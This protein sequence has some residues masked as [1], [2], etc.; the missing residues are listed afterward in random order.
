MTAYR[1]AGSL[2]CPDC[3]ASLRAFGARWVCDDCTGIFIR[4]D[5]LRRAIAE[6]GAGAIEL[7]AAEAE[8]ASADAAPAAPCPSCARP[9]DRFRIALREHPNVF[10]GG[11]PSAFPFR[12]DGVEL[13]RADAI[14]EDTTFPGCPAHGVWF[15]RGMLAGVFARINHKLSGGRGGSVRY[16]VGFAERGLRI[17]QRKP[18]PRVPA[19]PYASPFHGRMLPCP[20]CHDPLEQQGDHWSCE[21]CGGTFVESAALEAMIAEMLHAPYELPRPGGAPGGRLCPVCGELTS[22]DLLEGRPVE[23]CAAHGVWFARDEL[24]EVLAR[25]APGPR[26]GW[27]RR[28]FRR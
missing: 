18:K 15:A 10:R 6:M 21:R 16:A 22:G 7:A 3:H 9:M 17:S 27:L 24:S 1:E 28:F 8:P 14:D 12:A 23:R 13:V 19:T 4:Q 2:A 25:A 20:R 26:S 5:D 11:Y